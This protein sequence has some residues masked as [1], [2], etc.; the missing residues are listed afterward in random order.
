MFPLLIFNLSG[1]Y[2]NFN[3]QKGVKIDLRD[4]EGTS[5][6][7]CDAAK[8]EI[9]ARI[10]NIKK[11]FPG[12]SVNLI[13]SGDY[14]YMTALLCGQIREEFSLVLFDHHP[15]MQAPAFGNILSCGGWMRW[16]LKENSYLGKVLIIGISPK[17]LGE[18]GG[19]PGRTAVITENIGRAEI[20]STIKAW[21]PQGK[22]YISIDKDVLSQEYA[23]TNWDQGSMTLDTLCM[24]IKECLA[25]EHD[26]L[27]GV[28]IC[29]EIPPSKG[30]GDYGGSINAV[31][32]KRIADL[33][34]RLNA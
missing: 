20:L 34:Q 25:L 13:D 22:L 30:G 1:V 15:D 12:P 29:G 32:D 33:I 24:A 14:H 6:Y 18:T 7:C 2:D 26:G 9:P 5:C 23:L 8:D 28:D 27:I 21:K 31:A 10:S 3:P 19:F 16:M 17:L 4:V 11:Q